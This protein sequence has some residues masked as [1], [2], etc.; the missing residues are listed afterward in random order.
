[1]ASTLA[2]AAQRIGRAAGDDAD[3]GVGIAAIARRRLMW[4]IADPRLRAFGGLDPPGGFFVVGSFD[5]EVV[6]LPEGVK[7]HAYMR[8][9]AHRDQVIG[10]DRSAFGVFP[11]GEAPADQRFDP[12]AASLGCEH[13]DPA[14]LGGY[15]GGDALT[16]FA[17]DG[18]DPLCSRAEQ[19]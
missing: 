8:V 17:H 3:L 18:S 12:A 16:Y 4:A 7:S 9:H 10:A 1:M 19:P 13:G 15:D 11:M 14:A 6:G 2:R 5:A